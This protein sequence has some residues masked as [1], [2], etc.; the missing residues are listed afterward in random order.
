MNSMLAAI[1][2]SLDPEALQHQG[3]ET[4]TEEHRYHDN[5]QSGGKDELPLLVLSVADG[6]GKSNGTSQSSEHQHVLETEADLLGSG[7]VQDK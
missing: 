4:A 1:T 3:G 2:H 6:K 5:T 7:Q